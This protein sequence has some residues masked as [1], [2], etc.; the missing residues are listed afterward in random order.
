MRKLLV[1]FDGSDNARRALQYVVDLAGELK[2]VPQV[3]VINVQQEPVLYGEYVSASMIEE[4][5]NGLMAQ[6]RGL[7]DEAST[8]LKAAGIQAE[9]HTVMGNAADQISAAVSR[10]GCDTLVMGTRGLG[11]FTGLVMGSVTNRVVHES[12][13]PVVLVK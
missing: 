12:A 9:T 13:I 7:L 10:L 5:N 8:T 1:A 6:S 2:S 3:H 4:I 11:N